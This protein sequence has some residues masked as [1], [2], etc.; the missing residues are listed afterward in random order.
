ML[1]GYK[2]AGKAGTAEGLALEAARA[3]VPGRWLCT[4]LRV[5]QSL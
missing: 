4:D 5:Q 1:S 2:T 3:C